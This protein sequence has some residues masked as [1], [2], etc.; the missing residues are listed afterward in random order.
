MPAA[1]HSDGRDYPGQPG[2]VEVGG[3]LKGMRKRLQILR[4]LLDGRIVLFSLVLLLAGGCATLP[5]NYPREPSWAWDHPQETKLGRVLGADAEQHP[6]MSGFLPLDNGLD[7]F[8]ARMALAEAAEHALDLQYY[9]FHGDFTGKL[10]LDSIVR[11]ADRGVRVRILID[12]TTAKGRDAGIAILASHPHIEVRVFNPFAGRSSASWLFSAVADFDRINRRMHNKMFVA[13][14]EAGVVGGRNIGD[15]YFSAREGVNFAD[16]DLLAVGPVVQDLSRSFDQYWNSEWAYPIEALHKS[17]PDPTVLEKVRQ[18]LA[19]H[20]ETAKDSDYARRLRESDLRKSL[21][22]GQLP[23]I[24]APARVLVDRPEK[25][26]GAGSPEGSVKLGSQLRQIVEGARLEL[27]ISSPYFIPGNRGIRLFEQISN[28]GVRIRIVTNSFAGNDVAIAHSG[29]AKYRKSL[30]KLGVELHELKPSLTVAQEKE[31]SRF[32]SS[33]ASLHAKVFVIDRERVF[34][35][36]LNLDPRSVDLNTELGIVVEDRELASRIAQKLDVL[37]QP[38]YSYRV[39]LD[40]SDGDLVWISQ[41]DGK[42]VRYSK[43]PEVGFWRR[44]STWFLS[45]FAPESLL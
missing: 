10:I 3:G 34:V 19:A 6:G 12:D 16:L 40:P 35:G 5:K 17:K 43:D 44:T 8:V 41:E 2:P 14:N 4:R 33:S 36:S 37:A 13:D 23:L 31:R 32:G 21:M 28:K 38:R 9:I 22:D 11:A 29:Y 7:A 15:E 30:L 27:I 42:E 25:A 24:W 20:R 26:A 18:E 39:E 45:I 1:S